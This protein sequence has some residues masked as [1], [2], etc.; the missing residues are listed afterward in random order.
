[1][2]YF[3]NPGDGHDVRDVS[4]TEAGSTRGTLYRVSSHGHLE[5]FDRSTSQWYEVTKE[6]QAHLQ[7]KVLRA[8]GLHP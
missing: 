6:E 1:M 8:A 5:T 4:L 3:I 7:I 2:R